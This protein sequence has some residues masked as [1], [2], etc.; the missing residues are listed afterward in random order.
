MEKEIIKYEKRNFLR[1]Y[2]FDGIILAL[3]GIAM[4]VWPDNALKVLCVVVGGLV[5]VM[6]FIKFA[7]FLANNKAVRKTSDLIIGIIQIALGIALIIASDFFISLFFVVAGIILVYG[8]LLMFIRAFQLLKVKGWLFALSLIFAVV[9]LAFAVIIF[10]NPIQF[11]EFVT[12]IQGAAL[13][14]E[15][16]GMIIVLKNVKVDLIKVTD[17]SEN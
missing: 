11:A 1:S 5:A 4:L 14:I 17:Y 2:I 9:T 3:L 10:I 13:I 15:G 16:I 8:A 7:F 6:G 12:R